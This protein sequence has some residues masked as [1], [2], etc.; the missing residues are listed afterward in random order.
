M[1]TALVHPV[2]RN[3]GICPD[4]VARSDAMKKWILIGSVALVGI[5][6]AVGVYAQQQ[7]GIKPLSVQDY[8]E[9]QQLYMHYTW[10][11]DNHDQEA[12]GATFTPDGEFFV[13]GVNHVG[14]AAIGL[15]A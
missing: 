3:V 1:F 5:S 9:I 10:A 7:R 14:R 12:Y 4:K 6:A 15:L 13:G 2:R 8:M 11:I